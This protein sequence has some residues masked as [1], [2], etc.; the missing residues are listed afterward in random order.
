MFKEVNTSPSHSDSKSESLID[1][2]YHC[3]TVADQN[4]ALLG[5]TDIFTHYGRDSS[6]SNVHHALKPVNRLYMYTRKDCT[7]LPHLHNRTDYT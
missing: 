1:G 6:L 5:T 4:V 3:C 2:C 7:L